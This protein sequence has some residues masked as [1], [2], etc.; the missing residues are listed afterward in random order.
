VMPRIKVRLKKSL[1]WS[2]DLIPVLFGNCF[3][4]FDD[5]RGGYSMRLVIFCKFL[6]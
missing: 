2:M 3:C 6:T 1:R 5:S 4:V